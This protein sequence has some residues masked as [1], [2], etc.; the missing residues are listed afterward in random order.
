MTLAVGQKIP[1][2]ELTDHAGA[3]VRL[4]SLLGNKTVVLYFYPRDES[5][6]CTVEACAFRDAYEDF[7]QAGA[8]VIGVSRDG[9]DDHRAFKEKHRLPFVLLT[10]ARGEAAKT[11]GVARAA[12]GLLPG[13]VTFVIDRTGVLRSRFDSAVRMNAHVTSALELVKSLEA[14]A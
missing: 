10:D 2:V 4:S 7:T 11:L 1:D 8:E 14:K 6:G 13:R 9:A 3:T 12:F 5:P